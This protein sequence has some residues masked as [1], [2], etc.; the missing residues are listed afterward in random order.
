MNF[1]KP[2]TPEEAKL[3]VLQFLGQNL[4]DVKDLDSRIIN[5]TSTLQGVNIDP[6]KVIN[7]IPGGEVLQPPQPQAPVQ[8][9]PRPVQHNPVANIDNS[10][11]VK[12]FEKLCD[13]EKLLEKKK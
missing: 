7:S 12:I 2:V 10:I 3:T 9:M 11:F 5:K 4:G 6:R 8:Q 13:I 1:E